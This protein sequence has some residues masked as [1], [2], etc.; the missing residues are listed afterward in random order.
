MKCCR[1]RRCAR[2]KRLAKAPISDRLK[3]GSSPISRSS[4][5]DPLI[6]IKNARKVRTVIKNG[7]VHTLEEFVEA[8][9]RMQGF[10]DQ[11][12]SCRISCLTYGRPV[13]RLREQAGGPLSPERTS[14]KRE[15]AINVA[16]S[17]D[18]WR[19]SANPPRRSWCF[20]RS[21]KSVIAKFAT[22]D[23]YVNSGTSLKNGRS[24]R[25]RSSLA[26][27]LPKRTSV[28][29]LMPDPWHR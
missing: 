6:D 17:G 20:A 24:G 22:N 11:G 7:E 15:R 23:P 2:P 28:F 19:R 9:N 29:A 1:P 18:G 26:R 16:N 27:T 21:D 4:T 25:G 3:Q 5:D 14:F 8:V 12:E 13:R 10:R